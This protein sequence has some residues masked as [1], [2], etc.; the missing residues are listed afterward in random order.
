MAHRPL[1][2]VVSSSAVAEQKRQKDGNLQK[3]DYGIHPVS[4]DYHEN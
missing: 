3:N 4:P 1:R 2:R